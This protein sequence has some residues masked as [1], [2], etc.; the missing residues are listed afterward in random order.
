MKA[1]KKKPKMKFTVCYFCNVE[2]SILKWQLLGQ[3]LRYQEFL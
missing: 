1:T 3:E 2:V